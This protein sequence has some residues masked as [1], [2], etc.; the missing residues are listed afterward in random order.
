MR[1]PP[2]RA[3]IDY[4]SQVVAN[5]NNPNVDN[6]WTDNINLTSVGVAAAEGF[7]TSG[8]SIGKTILVKTTAAVVNN[9]VEVKTSSKNAKFGVK[10]DLNPVNVAKNTAIDLTTDAI[11]GG[12][13][14]E[15]GG[16]TKKALKSSGVTPGKLADETKKIIKSTGNNINRSTNNAVKQGSKQAIKGAEK[17]TEKGAEV[18]IKG[19]SSGTKDKIKEKTRMGGPDPVKF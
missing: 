16:A 6:P 19:K 3:A 11:T 18:I 14:K 12:L 9:V 2:I 1:P 13:A 10:V 7:L 5:Y 17:V 4:G 15:A 8:A